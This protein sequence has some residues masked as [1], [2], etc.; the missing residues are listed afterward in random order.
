M[1]PSIHATW[2]VSQGVLF[3]MPLKR[4]L[5]SFACARLLAKI[6]GGTVPV[7]E[8]ITVMAVGT[9]RLTVDTTSWR[10]ADEDFVPEDELVVAGPDLVV[11]TEAVTE[12]VVWL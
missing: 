7:D 5:Y 8:G 1:S 12:A 6:A 10:E 3:F 11:R 2:P 9:T 4:V